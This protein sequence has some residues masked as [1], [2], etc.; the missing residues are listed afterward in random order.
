MES[1]QSSASVFSPHVSFDQSESDT[2]EMTVT[3]SMA[4]KYYDRLCSANT[5]DPVV[6]Y[7]YTTKKSKSSITN[8]VSTEI[9]CNQLAKINSD[10]T[11]FMSKVK[12]IVSDYQEKYLKTRMISRDLIC[13]K[14]ALHK[15]N[16][17]L[18]VDRLLSE[19]GFVNAQLTA[20]KD[21][22]KSSNKQ[23]YYENSSDLFS[24]YKDNESK[25][26]H[27]SNVQMTLSVFN[28]DELENEIKLLRKHLTKLENQ[29]LE[30]NSTKYVTFKLSK[31]SLDE[32]GLD[33]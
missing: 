33:E 23:N 11:S 8:K 5:S 22:V 13:L 32:L 14:D 24:T 19:E 7:G 30:K 21:I 3:L 20:L 4:Q 1:S 10:F 27:S 17:E 28:V 31:Y 26:V 16:A 18:G 29:R 2:K 15:R 25:S 6:Q 9:D 12:P